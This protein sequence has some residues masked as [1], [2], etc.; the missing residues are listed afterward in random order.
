MS[1]LRSISQLGQNVQHVAYEHVKVQWRYLR[2][3]TSVLE[4]A[5]GF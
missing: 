3:S 2:Q 5:G 4:G 1:H